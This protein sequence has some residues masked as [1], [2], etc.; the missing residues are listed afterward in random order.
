M[1]R[2]NNQGL[3]SARS[4]ITG[5]K[6]NDAYYNKVQSIVL[7]AA[8]KGKTIASAKR[9]TAELTDR[10]INL[11]SDKRVET[12]MGSKKVPL[13]DWTAGHFQKL[14]LLSR[15]VKNEKDSLPRLEQLNK[16]GKLEGFGL[17]QLKNAPQSIAKREKEYKDLRNDFFKEQNYVLK[18]FDANRKDEKHFNPTSRSIFEEAYNELNKRVKQYLETLPENP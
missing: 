10:M 1:A 6:T 2:G 12:F 13:S 11:W 18:T 8:Y 7:G 15:S 3:S 4:E 14:T 17:E 16:E 5:G 9:S